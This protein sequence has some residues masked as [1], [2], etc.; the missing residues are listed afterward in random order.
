MISDVPV[1]VL[2]SG[3]VDSTGIL[4]YAVDQTDKQIHTFTIGF[5][6]QAF[7]DERP[8][9]RLAAKTFGTAHH[10]ITMTAQD[11]EKIMASE[12][13]MIVKLIEYIHVIPPENRN[14]FIPSLKEKY[15]MVLRNQKWDLV[16][17]TEFINNLV[18]SKNIMLEKLQKLVSMIIIQNYLVRL[19][20]G[21]TA[22][23]M[24]RVDQTVFL[25]QI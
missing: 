10:E 25:Q 5:D 24:I 22:C 20:L 8:Y 7:A 1:G 12:F 2:L 23:L 19:M 21:F 6:G 9:A 15:A 13:N 3:G 18:I 16:D 17:R 14:A 4:R 11:C